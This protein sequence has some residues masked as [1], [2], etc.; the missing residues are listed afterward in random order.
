MATMEVER[1]QEALVDS[2]RTQIATAAPQHADL[3]IETLVEAISARK[4]VSVTCRKCNTTTRA[5]VLDAVAATNAIKLLIEQT[6]GR[7]GVAGDDGQQAQTIVRYVGPVDLPALHALA[8]A[9][10]GAALIA[11]VLAAGSQQRDLTP[12]RSASN[13]C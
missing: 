12:A 9:G 13:V 3:V 5:E 10:D 7:P 2:L 4:H 6:E 8:Q 11:A 1:G